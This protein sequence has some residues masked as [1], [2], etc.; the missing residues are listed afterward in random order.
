[1]GSLSAAQHNVLDWKDDKDVSAESS[2]D[3]SES[4]ESGSSDDGAGPSPA[5][6]FRALERLA[7]STWIS[8]S[9]FKPDG[10]EGVSDITTWG[11]AWELG[12]MT[13]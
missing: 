5:K 4:I 6:R 13:S 8:E 10:V 11:G 2:D 1:M 12:G 9:S 3:D 7:S